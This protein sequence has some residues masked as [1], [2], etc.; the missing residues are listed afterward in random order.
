MLS[1]FRILEQCDIVVGIGVSVIGQLC[2][3]L[4]YLDL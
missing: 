3:V 1:M 4:I 2:Y